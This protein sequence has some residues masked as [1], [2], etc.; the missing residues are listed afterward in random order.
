M[1]REG[2][3]RLVR[4]SLRVLTAGAV[5]GAVVWGGWLVSA[6][7]RKKSEA[8]PAVAKATPMRPPELRTDGV[9]DGAWL[10]RTL[11]LPEGASLM[12]LDL[13][14]LRA[15]L[16]AESQVAGATLTKHFPDRLVV[17]ITER[18]PVARVMMQFLGQQKALLVGRD[19]VI[20]AGEGYDASIL[21]TLPWL[22]G[23]KITPD[24]GG[25]QP[26]AGMNAAAELLGKAR[27]E[28]DHL[29]AEWNVVSLARLQSDR[30]LEIR[31]KDGLRTIYFTT[32]DDFFRQLAKLDY[33][34]E[35]LNAKAPGARAVIDLSLGQD[36]PV[37]VAALEAEGVRPAH[38]AP[39]VRTPEP[40]A[41][42]LRWTTAR[43]EPGAGGAGIQLR[44][45]GSSASAAPSGT[46][47][48]T[49]SAQPANAFFIPPRSQSKDT[50]R[51]F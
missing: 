11:A 12:E 18:G 8:M 4:A 30:K 29:Y 49:A 37:Q 24:G 40:A 34:T 7:V 19:G 50:Q 33:I 2:K 1:S 42:R 51:E 20:Y 25:F 47:L 32:T 36:V 5:L 31:T 9:L 13:A 28:A 35:A 10:L 45:P 46:L 48:R 27:L 16:L 3:W 17:Q 44:L 38:P 39:A 21:D 23:V 14:T 41:P 15:R 43:P 22:D 6:A 26:I